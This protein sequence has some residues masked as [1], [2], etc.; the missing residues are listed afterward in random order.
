MLLL[1]TRKKP[2]ETLSLRHLR[3]GFHLLFQICTKESKERLT[4]CG[5]MIL[6]WR[7]EKRTLRWTWL[8]LWLTGRTCEAKTWLNIRH[9]RLSYIFLRRPKGLEGQ[10]LFVQ[11]SELLS[12]LWCRPHDIQMQI[13]SA[14][15][16]HWSV[17]VFQR[18][19]LELWK[20]LQSL[21][22][23]DIGNHASS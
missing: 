14:F 16:G 2:A 23:I 15:S 5:K 22:A 18:G 17:L 1:A 6:A 11:F 19:N 12:C 7:H 10:R 8:K 21:D 13:L 20:P 9:I 4:I 3:E